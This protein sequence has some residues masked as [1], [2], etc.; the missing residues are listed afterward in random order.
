[1]EETVDIS[2]ILKLV[3]PSE[4]AQQEAFERI[5]ELKKKIDAG[6]D[7]GE[8]ASQ[9]SEDPASAKRNGDL[10]MISRGDFV[11]EFEAAAFSL[12]DGE[13]SDIVQTTFGFHIIKMIE[14][15]GEKIRTQHILIR[16][17]PTEN[18]EQRIVSELAE[19]R[20]QI[21]NGADFSELALTHS[22]DENVSQDQGHLGTFEVSKMV[23]PEFKEV[24]AGLNS[25]EISEP[26]KTEFGYHIVRLEDRKQSRTFSLEDDWQTIEEFALNQKMEMEYR[27]WIAELKKD[28][29]IQIKEN[30]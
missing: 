12:N 8:L 15:R 23:V 24:I 2:H 18:D 22:D 17:M 19:L 25:G 26:F 1:M 10:G 13:I 16:V 14:R 6:A 5:V 30:I 9:Y 28:V 11:P 7:F 21:Q 3:Q 29:P 20:E 4:Q 27:D